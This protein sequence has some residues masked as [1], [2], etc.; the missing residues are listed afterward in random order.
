MMSNKCAA[1]WLIA[2]LIRLGDEWSEG[3]PQDDEVTFV[4]LKIK[5]VV[6]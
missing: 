1:I 3:R 2:D 4:V 6:R 5:D